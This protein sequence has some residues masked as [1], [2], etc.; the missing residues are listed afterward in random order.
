MDGFF[1]AE[2][3][4][5]KHVRSMSAEDVQLAIAAAVSQL[6]ECN[7]EA[8]IND[9]EFD[10]STNGFD[11]LSGI[12]HMNCSLRLKVHRRSPLGAMT[13]FEKDVE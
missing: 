9:I 10:K 5:G 4:V 1:A 6:A 7:C 11:Q 3:L 12:E 2:K 8:E 13:D